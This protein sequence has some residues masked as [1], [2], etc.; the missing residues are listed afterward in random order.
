MKRIQ[1]LLNELRKTAKAGDNHCGRQKEGDHRKDAR[2]PIN[3]PIGRVSNFGDPFTVT[4]EQRL[5]TPAGEAT[6]L[7]PKVESVPLLWLS[8]IRPPSCMRSKRHMRNVVA[9][10]SLFDC[11]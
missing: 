11:H 9:A 1:H 8:Q 2:D 7:Y 6:N 3:N 5:A 4:N 10:E